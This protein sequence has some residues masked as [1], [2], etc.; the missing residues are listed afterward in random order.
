[1]LTKEQYEYYNRF[2]D[3]IELFNKTGQY[4]GGCNDLFVFMNL[5]KENLNCDNCKAAALIE[6][7]QFIDEYER[8]MSSV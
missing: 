5:P 2:R 6:A 3:V 8:N 7:K 4:V 1:M